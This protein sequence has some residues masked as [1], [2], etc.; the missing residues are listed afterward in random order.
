MTSK[1][2]RITKFNRCIQFVISGHPTVATI[3]GKQTLCKCRYTIRH[4]GRDGGA[5]QRA[6]IRTVRGTVNVRSEM[7]AL[8]KR[9]LI[10]CRRER[11][12]HRT[13]ARYSNGRSSTT[14]THD[15]AAPTRPTVT[16]GRG[17]CTGHFP[18]VDGDGRSTR[19]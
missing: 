12:N 19:V 2:K 17:R 14:P 16:F 5:S 4:F 7:D 10:V 13:F 8:A 15:K 9:V 11:P 1:V 3:E 18:D 6:K